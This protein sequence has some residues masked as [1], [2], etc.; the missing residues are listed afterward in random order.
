MM[1]LGVVHGLLCKH[2]QEAAIL[3]YT[4]LGGV[5]YTVAVFPQ[6]L[7][8]FL[9]QAHPVLASLVR[10]VTFVP[11]LA[12]VALT[13]YC[14]KSPFN[15]DEYSHWQGHS[16]SKPD[17]QRSVSRSMFGG[18]TIGALGAHVLSFKNVA[19]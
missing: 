2:P 13:A 11:S 1:E 8:V 6:D 16:W 5:L 15:K 4:F 19:N 7:P 14:Q 18:L 9:K 12:F 3:S 10:A 17:W